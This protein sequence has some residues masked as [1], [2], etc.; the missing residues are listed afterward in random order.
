MG[1]VTRYNGQACKAFGEVFI[2]GYVV[3]HLAIVELLV[4]NEVE[5]ACAGEAEEYGLLFAGLPAPERFIYCN[6]YC[7]A[8]FRSRQ[9]AFAARELLR[10]FENGCLLNGS[11]LHEPVMVELAEDGGHAVEAQAAGVVRRGDES[12]AESVH[13]CERADHA[14]V[15]EVIGELSPGEAWA[16]SRL[17]CDDLIIRLASELLAHERGGWSRRLHSL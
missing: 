10:R 17:H 4:S 5:V 14:R 7:V 1:S 16:R 12:A 6:L 2:G 8:A 3:G 11:G 13:L 9:D 15:A